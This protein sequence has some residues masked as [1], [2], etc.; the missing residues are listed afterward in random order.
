MHL[1]ET[2]NFVRVMKFSIEEEKKKYFQ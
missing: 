1:K 2:I